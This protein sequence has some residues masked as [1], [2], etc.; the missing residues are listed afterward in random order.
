M[1]SVDVNFLRTSYENLLDTPAIDK[2]ANLEYEFEDKMRFLGAPFGLESELFAAISP[3]PASTKTEML[4]ESSDAII[5][6]DEDLTASALLGGVTAL[7]EE[8]SNE[9]KNTGV[10][11]GLR[12]ADRSY[13][14]RL[15]FYLH[16][17]GILC[18][19]KR[20]RAEIYSAYLCGSQWP[21]SDRL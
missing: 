4:S 16:F 10:W 21:L 9:N 2:S 6:T 3:S 7:N 20:I 13:V 11:S 8:P 15:I 1:G 17:E 18:Y 12:K 5:K 14:E 19:F